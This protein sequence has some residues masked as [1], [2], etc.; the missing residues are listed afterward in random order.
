MATVALLVIVTLIYVYVLDRS[1]PPEGITEAKLEQ[2]I[3]VTADSSTILLQTHSA[4][5]GGDY[6]LAVDLACRSAMATLS[7]VLGM[8]G[9]NPEGMNASDLAYL[10]QTKAKSLSSNFRVLLP[11][12]HVASRK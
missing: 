7:K 10:V 11:V 6:A 8:A 1:P 4:I 2:Q 12:E 3:S 5:L 9:G